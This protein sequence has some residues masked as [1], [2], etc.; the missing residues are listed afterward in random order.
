MGVG[1]AWLSKYLV[2][3]YAT[4]GGRCNTSV[5]STA[6]MVSATNWGLSEERKSYISEV[7]THVG[8]PTHCRSALIGSRG[9]SLGMRVIPDVS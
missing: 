8:G 9:G 5:C 6:Y 1:A 4:P 2:V 3:R 7:Y